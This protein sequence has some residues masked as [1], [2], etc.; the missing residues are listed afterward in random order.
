MQPTSPKQTSRLKSVVGAVVI[1]AVLALIL[2]SNSAPINQADVEKRLQQLAAVTHFTYGNI[3]MT[4]K[5]YEKYI[6]VHDVH[7]SSEATGFSLETGSVEVIRDPLNNKRLIFRLPST[8]TISKNGEKKTLSFPTPLAFGYAE[9]DAHNSHL[10]LHL[11]PQMTVAPATGSEQPLVIA[12]DKLPD[13]HLDTIASLAQKE[14]QAE[15]HNITVQNGTD[16]QINIGEMTL[17]ITEKSANAPQKD[18]LFNFTIS[19]FTRLASV[20]KASRTCSFTS[21][22]AY[23][24]SQTLIRLSGAPSDIH[25]KINKVMLACEGFAINV[26][27]DIARTA[28][29]ALPS[30]TVNVTIDGVKTFLDSDLISDQTRS[31][32]TVALPKI[33]GQPFDTLSKGTFPVKRDA[34]GVMTLGTVNINELGITILKNLFHNEGKPQ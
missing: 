25:G 21:N 23:T 1:V 22:I 15:L 17:A 14:L 27:G 28:A 29:D 16:A 3:E 10:T 4:G 20:N 11:P 19:D 8:V 6:V 5:G 34:T 33:T 24:T 13:I 18:G 9:D 2:F 31:E 32:L 30:G 7:L 26:D 12:Y